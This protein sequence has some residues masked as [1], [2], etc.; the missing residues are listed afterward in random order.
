MIALPVQL[1]LAITPNP[2]RSG[3]EIQFSLPDATEGARLCIYDLAGRLLRDFGKT[4]VSPGVNEVRWDG[5]DDNGQ[6]VMNGIYFIRLTVN[7]HQVRATKALV[8]R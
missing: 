2:V 7:D 3:G 5:T 4:Y 6:P 1:A 8:V